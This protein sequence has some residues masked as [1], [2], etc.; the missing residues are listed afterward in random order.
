MQK[1][2]LKKR[3]PKVKMTEEE[4]QR[5]R[6]EY[7]RNYYL[8]HQDKVREYQLAYNVAHRKKRRPDSSTRPRNAIVKTTFTVSDLQGATG[9]RLIDRLTKVLNG[10]RGLVS[11]K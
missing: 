2:R 9:T 3:V 4:A 7:Q 1:I 8:A 11:V 5:R 6:A 10:E